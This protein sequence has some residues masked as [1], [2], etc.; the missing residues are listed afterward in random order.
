MSLSQLTM[1][2]FTIVIDI[3]KVR[4]RL[5][6]RVGQANIMYVSKITR[7]VFATPPPLSPGDC[8]LCAMLCWR[9]NSHVIWLYLCCISADLPPPFVS[10][11][12]HF[13]PF[14]HYSG[15]PGLQYSVFTKQEHNKHLFLHNSQT[16][17][18]FFIL[19]TY[20]C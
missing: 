17:R 12:L 15:M 9:E 11:Y 14:P 10:I 6:E 1:L 3:V 18:V 7:R 13:L 19:Y 5:R 20:S 8:R 4:E 2:I 16:H